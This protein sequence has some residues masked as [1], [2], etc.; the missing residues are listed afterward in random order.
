E[1]L[2]EGDATEVRLVVR[3]DGPG[4][5]PERM[6]Q[7]LQHT[8]ATGTDAIRLARLSTSSPNAGRMGLG[9]AIVQR[10]VEGHGGHVEAHNRADR[11]G[12]GTP[13]ASFVVHLPRHAS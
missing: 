5:A 6:P 10:A 11:E 2:V 1:I 7:L 13:G 12:P 4:I 8:K 9:L 3:D